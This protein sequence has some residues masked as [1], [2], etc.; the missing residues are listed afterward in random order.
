MAKEV[1]ENMTWVWWVNV[2]YTPWK[3][4]GKPYENGVLMGLLGFMLVGGWGI[5]TP[6]NNMRNHELG[7]WHSQDM[8]KS[9]MCQSPP[10]REHGDKPSECLGFPQFTNKDQQGYFFSH[11]NSG[12]WRLPNIMFHHPKTVATGKPN[13]SRHHPTT[14]SMVCLATSSADFQCRISFWNPGIAELPMNCGPSCYHISPLPTA[15]GY[16]LVNS[17]ISMDNHHAM[18]GK[19]HYSHGNFQ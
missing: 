2:R 9:N 15:I 18:N 17:H 4:I 8:E 5:P 1:L 3:T 6:R 11:E 16:P 10:T 13:G 7:W 12:W 19:T 14:Q